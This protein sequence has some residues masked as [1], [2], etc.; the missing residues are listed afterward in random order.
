MAGTRK[1]KRAGRLERTFDLNNSK[2]LGAGGYG[3]VFSSG[4]KAI[5]LLY[6]LDSCKDLYREAQIQ[7]KAREILKG[8]VQVPRVYSYMSHPIQVKNVQY[9]CGIEMERVPVLEGFE[10]PLHILLGYHGDEINTYW[11]KATAVPVGPQNPSRG[12]FAG[13]EFLEEIFADG[14]I[15]L[16]GVAWKM[17][18]ALRALLDWGILPNDLEFIYGGDG[19][20]YLIDFGLCEFGKADPEDFLNR[21]GSWGLRSDIYIPHRGDRGYEEFMNGFLQS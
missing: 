15:T 16:E 7:E 18:V 21:R 8:V 6:D 5:K 13:P 1:R 14:G 9:L 4:H 20:I 2:L 11:G 17:G 19:K 12:F 10:G 3:V